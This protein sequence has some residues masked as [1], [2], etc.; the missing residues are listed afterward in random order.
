MANLDNTWFTL[1]IDDGCTT[2]STIHNYCDH[3]L[4][5]NDSATDIA[6]YDC[7]VRN[8]ADLFIE[9]V[10]ETIFKE[11]DD[12]CTFKEYFWY[13]MGG[14][15]PLLLISLCLLLWLCKQCCCKNNKNSN[16]EDQLAQ[17]GSQLSSHHNH[18]QQKETAYV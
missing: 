9:G 2:D 14:A 5:Y 12:Y 13:A 18:Q 7:N 16:N 1:D 4:Y 10:M 11:V 3:C 6:T 15:A 17:Q 8:I